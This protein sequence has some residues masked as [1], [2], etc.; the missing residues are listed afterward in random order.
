MAIITLLN[1]K[2]GV[3]KSTTTFHLGGALAKLGQRVL[4]VDND[5]QGSLTQGFLGRDVH[6]STSPRK[7]LAA[8]YA[9]IPIAPEDL[10]GALPFAG[11]SLIPNAGDSAAF[12]YPSP[13][14]RP[15]EEQTALTDALGALTPRYDVILI[16]CPPNLGLATWAA[17]AASDGLIIPVQPEDFGIQGLDDVLESINLVRAT[18]N[19]RLATVGI[20]V[21]M[22]GSRKSV[23]TA[24]DELLRATYGE[25]M[26]LTRI[27]YTIDL[28]EA[29]MKH[30]PISW[31][32]PRS[33]AAKAL[34]ALAG[35]VTVRLA[36]GPSC[37]GHTR[38]V[39]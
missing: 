11:L 26:F 19:P 14:E 20:L 22:F 2:G 15:W 7:T 1:Q 33:A 8:V 9:G 13:H 28:P 6:R 31:L 29:T 21:S 23:H 12:N 30:T 27:P 35:E 37:T 18:I 36:S 5:P 3:G 16:D 10:V 24:F 25:T 4:L 34:T 17:L 32:K 38:E 39:A